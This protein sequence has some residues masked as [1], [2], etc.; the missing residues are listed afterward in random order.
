MKSPAQFLFWWRWLIVVTSGLMLFGITMFVAPELT[1]H[2]FGF[3][4]FSSSARL[5]ALGEPAVAYIT[6]LHGV[7]GAVI[8]GWG[9]A[10][11]FVLVG[12]FRRGSKESW[13]IFV[14]SLLAWFIPDTVFSL[15]SGFW[16]NAALNAVL[17]VLFAVPLAATHRL[18]EPVT[19]E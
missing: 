3:L 1:R 15:W 4:L 18:F 13:R 9:V 7:L 8:F 6:L 12:P 16:Q 14:I 11:L 10:L 19:D 5:D 17:A 2:L